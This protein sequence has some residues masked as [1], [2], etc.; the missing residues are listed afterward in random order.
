[1]VGTKVLRAPPG[2]RMNHFLKHIPS[3]R[4]EWKTWYS[5]LVSYADNDDSDFG[6]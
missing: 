4:F 1:M 6:F 2:S 5:V 3:R